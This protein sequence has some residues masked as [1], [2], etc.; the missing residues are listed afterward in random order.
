MYMWVAW[1]GSTFKVP[2]PRPMKAGF[3]L[4]H[5]G[6]FLRVPI[7]L[8]SNFHPLSIKSTRKEQMILILNQ[9]VSRRTKRITI[10][11]DISPKQIHRSC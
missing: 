1:L 6:Y 3:Y 4:T 2:I 8:G 9:S 5:C 11:Q 7:G 10:I